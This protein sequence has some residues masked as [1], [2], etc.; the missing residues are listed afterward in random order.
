MMIMR[1]P[2]NC[3]IES[4]VLK[5]RGKGPSQTIVTLAKVKQNTNMAAARN[6]YLILGFMVTSK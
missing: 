3:V 5:Y 4:R 6:I 2:D 1:T